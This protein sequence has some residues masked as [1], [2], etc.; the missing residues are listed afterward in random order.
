VTR[1]LAT[2][3]NS[4]VVISVEDASGHV[5]DYYGILQKLIEYTFDDAK[6]SRVVFSV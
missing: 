6:E 2:T 5:C 1:L 4:K 3:L